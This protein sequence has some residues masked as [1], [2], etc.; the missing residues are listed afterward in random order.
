MRQTDTLQLDFMTTIDGVRSVEGVR[1]RS[2]EFNVGGKK[3]R[4]AAL[5]DVVA[6]KK[7]ANR[8]SDQAVL[9]ILDKTL[10]ASG[11]ASPPQT[12]PQPGASARRAAKRK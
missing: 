1:A 4:V 8:P 12:H 7:S 5:A 10:N 6:S 2:A 3:L 9:A 11:Q